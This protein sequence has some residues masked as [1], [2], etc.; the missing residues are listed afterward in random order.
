MEKRQ[1][2]GER[3]NARFGAGGSHRD[4]EAWDIGTWFTL[5]LSEGAALIP[6]PLCQ[7]A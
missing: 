6:Q 1:E 5:R 3:I 2:V 7:V 4:I